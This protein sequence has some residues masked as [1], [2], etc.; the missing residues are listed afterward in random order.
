MS[1]SYINKLLEYLFH[2][3]YS[4]L[5][6]LTLQKTRYL[7]SLVKGYKDS[8]DNPLATRTQAVQAVMSAVH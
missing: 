8:K 1:T 5:Y 3:H 4:Y 2:F 7:L 6:F